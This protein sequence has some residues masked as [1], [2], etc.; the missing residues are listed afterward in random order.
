MTPTPKKFL[1]VDDENLI[2]F[3][4]KEF[5]KVHDLLVDEATN[6]REAIEKWELGEYAGILMDIKMPEIDGFEAT[7]VIRRREKEQGR[8]Y[9]PIFAVSGCSFQNFAGQCN[10][11]GMD[12]CIAKPVDFEK[13]VD[14]LLPLAK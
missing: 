5:F 12:G 14:L 13:L 7:R 1:V 3:Y 8:R 10:E 2:R 11:A 9:T 6:G 4:L